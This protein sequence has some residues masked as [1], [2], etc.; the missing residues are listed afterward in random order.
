MRTLVSR[1]KDVRQM[2]VYGYARLVGYA[3]D[4]SL[5]PDILRDFEVFEDRRYTLHLRPGHK[6]SDGAPF[7]SDDFRYWWENVINNDEI[8]PTGTAGF[9]VRRWQPGQRYLSRPPHSC[10]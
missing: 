9:H 5:Y 1:T 2:V 8:T 3:P 4:Y 7:T 10:F 6:W